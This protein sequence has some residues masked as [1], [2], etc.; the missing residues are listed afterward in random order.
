MRKSRAYSLFL[1]VPAAMILAP[2][3]QAQEEIL[4]V[5]SR[6]LPNGRTELAITN[7]SEKQMVTAYILFRPSSNPQVYRS[8]PEY[9]DILFTGEQHNFM[10]AIMPLET[11]R[12]RYPPASEKS[13]NDVEEVKAAVF[14]DGATWGDS[15]WVQRIL[16]CRRAY[17]TDLTVAIKLIRHALDEDMPIEK[18]REEFKQL[19][20][21]AS[22]P[23]ENFEHFG[24]LKAAGSVYGTVLAHLQTPTAGRDLATFVPMLATWRMVIGQSKPSIVPSSQ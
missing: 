21:L 23:G 19:R 6:Q 2:A 12:F 13:K 9:Y 24:E 4:T 14:S 3:I 8:A 22:D 10:D 11:K 7:N 17:Y 18:L 5:E 20:D 1:V 16:D 15:E